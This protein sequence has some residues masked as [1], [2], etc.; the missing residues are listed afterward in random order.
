MPGGDIVSGIRD[1]WPMTDAPQ[2]RGVDLAD[3][4]VDLL[5][6]LIQ[7][8]TTNAG[9]DPATVGEFRAAALVADLLDDAGYTPHRFHTTDPTRAGV[10]LRV[11]GTD[12]DAASRALLLH[13]HLDVV[14]ADPRNW[15]Q[16]PFLAR[17]APDPLSG[18]EM[19]WGRGAVDMKDMVAMMIAILRHWAR[20]GTRPRRDI[21][22]AFLPDEEAGGRHGSHWLVEHHP[23]WFGGV[24]EAVGEV[25]GFSL[26]VP[27]GRRLYLVQTAEKGIA[28]LQLTASGTAG[29]GSV[30][31]PDNAITRLAQAVARIG[32]HEFPVQLTATT[33]AFL[34]ALGTELGVHIDAADPSSLAGALGPHGRFVGATMSHTANPTMLRG[35]YKVNVIPDNA[36][37]QV[38]GRFLPGGEQ[39]FLATID[40]LAGPGVTAE[41]LVGDIALE[42][43][44]DGATVATMAAVLARHDPGSRAVPYMLSAGTDAKAFARLGVRCYGFVPL[45]L[46]PS[47]DFGS[48]FHGVDERV[49]ISGLQF[50]V[51]VLEEFLRTC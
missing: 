1:D 9:P 3:E 8:D 23:D 6:A 26:T 42:T 46:P 4:V 24:T 7:V 19:V 49:P 43:T 21:V 13:G 22:V 10:I 50:G 30:R 18:E 51:G 2:A 17:I 44:F 29:H 14:P 15:T 16:P 45:R 35:G 25:G 33:G 37:A 32:A 20:T 31:N 27:A 39:E 28:W 5:V 12:P 34:D 48:L 38:D 47:L 36:T 41:V 40:Q 11:P